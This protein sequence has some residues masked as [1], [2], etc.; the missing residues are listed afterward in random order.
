MIL[1]IDRARQEP[2]RE[3]NARAG[4]LQQLVRWPAQSTRRRPRR[5]SEPGRPHACCPDGS[6]PRVVH[7]GQLPELA[8]RTP[9]RRIDVGTGDVDVIRAVASRAAGRPADHAPADQVDGLL[10]L[11]LPGVG[12][13]V[14]QE[15]ALEAA[16]R[17]G[18][19]IAEPPRLRIRRERRYGGVRPSGDATAREEQAEA[20]KSRRDPWT[21]PHRHPSVCKVMPT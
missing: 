3:A 4:R 5:P 12:T 15:N 19:V 11:A 9:E 6:L 18:G 14:H 8:H 13:E 16:V 1:R 20:E 17:D 10:A 21:A 7:L 2:A